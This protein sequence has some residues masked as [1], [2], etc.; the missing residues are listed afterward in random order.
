MNNR[1]I[2]AT[3][4]LILAMRE[5]WMNLILDGKKT[6][7]VRRTRPAR[8]CDMPDYL[9]LY[10]K[11]HVHGL[12]EVRAYRYL[13]SGWFS[14]AVGE[15]QEACLSVEDAKSYLGGSGFGVV[16]KLGKVQRFQKPVPVPC[17]PQSWMY[18]TTEL[19]NIIEGK[20]QTCL[21]C[22]YW[23]MWDHSCA[24]RAAAL[25]DFSPVNPDTPACKEFLPE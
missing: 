4:Y 15:C 6:A 19:R 25:D 10:H 1:P 16:Y 20:P 8:P 17:R 3:S 11:G 24:T 18:A 13:P 22:R 21:N 23:S 14:L 7:E 2:P 5:R 12:A 9:Y